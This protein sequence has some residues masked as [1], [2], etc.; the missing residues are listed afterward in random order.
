[1]TEPALNPK[2]NKDTAAQV[3]FETYNVPAVYFA[4]QAVL[5]LYDSFF[6]FFFFFLFFNK[7]MKNDCI[8]TGILLAA[9]LGLC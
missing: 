7:L 8:S 9:R 4:V 5:S 3:L 1:M 6:S 2:K